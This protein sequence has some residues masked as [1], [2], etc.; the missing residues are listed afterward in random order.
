M[1]RAEPSDLEIRNDRKAETICCSWIMPCCSRS[2]ITS[3]VTV[4]FSGRL[5]DLL[6]EVAGL[7]LA[8]I[9]HAASDQCHPAA[10]TAGT[11]A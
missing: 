10:G 8:G 1:N 9:R 7:L 4:A 6:L 5:V 2:A 3:M 11:T